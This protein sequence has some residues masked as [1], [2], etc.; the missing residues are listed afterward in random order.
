MRGSDT[1]EEARPGLAVGHQKPGLG[2]AVRLQLLLDPPCKPQ[3][4]IELRN[5]AGAH[6]A[7]RITGVSNVHDDP[8]FRGI[9]H[10]GGRFQSGRAQGDRP[11]GGELYSVVLWRCGWLCR[12]GWLWRGDALWRVVLLRRA[13]EHSRPTAGIADLDRQKRQCRHRG[14]DGA[15]AGPNVKACPDEFFPQ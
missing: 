2:K 10:G 7:V 8:E 6:R 13:F 1:L 15:A 4:E 11:Q 9:A 12:F 3:V 14:D 5:I